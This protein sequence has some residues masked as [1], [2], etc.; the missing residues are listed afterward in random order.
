MLNL[1]ITSKI[2]LEF[3]NNSICYT[4]NKQVMNEELYCQGQESADDLFLPMSLWESALVTSGVW[5]Y[6]VVRD[7]WSKYPV[8]SSV[9]LVGGNR[10]LPRQLWSCTCECIYAYAKSSRAYINVWKTYINTKQQEQKYDLNSSLYFRS[11]IRRQIDLV[12]ILPDAQQQFISAGYK[13]KNEI[14][15]CKFEAIFSFC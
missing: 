8:L 1:I 3:I 11:N 4:C 5:V 7:S 12:A 10:S 15:C 9:R 14:W 2:L 6:T 13:P